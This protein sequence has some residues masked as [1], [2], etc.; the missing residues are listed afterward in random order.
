MKTY[1]DLLKAID[2]GKEMQFVKDCIDSHKSSTLYQEAIVAREY[3]RKRNVTIKVFQK[4]LYDMT[5]QA[6]PDNYSANYKLIN[7][8]FPIFVTQENNYLLG[9]GVT[10]NGKDT[11]D[12]VGGDE[13][14]DVLMDAGEKALWG[15]LSFGFFNVDKVKVFDVTEFAPLW[16]ENDGSLKAGVKFWQID[17]NKPLWAILFKLDGW[18]EYK[19]VAGKKG[20]AVK[21]N[22]PYKL[23]IRTSEFDG[24]EILKGENYPSF[25][26]VPLWANK[27]HQSEFIGLQEKIDC[28]DLIQSGF[29]N[30]IDDASVIYWT[31]QNAGGMDDI[32]LVKF[33]ERMKTVKAA[34]VDE[35]GSS[36]QAHTLEI[37]YA[38]RATL[39][40]DLRDS[41]YRDA[42][43]L[44]T[45]KITAGN[46]TATA[47]KSSY[48][49][50]DLKCDG[51]E[52][53]VSNFIKGI[54]KLANI[55]D[56]P[57]YKRNKIINMQED[58]QMVLSAAQYL[59]DETILKHLPFLSPDEIET[60]LDKRVEEEAA[61]FEE[62]GEGVNGQGE[63]ANR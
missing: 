22:Q 29:A 61:R 43:A 1:Q 14:D 4:L 23:K 31:I 55:D 19:W 62:S 44:D 27:N 6:I 17:N 11:K 5:G 32:D 16:D 47:I 63:E 48:S 25:P 49:N 59:D 46:V 34:V 36:A 21:E 2:E 58:T 13:F 37:P 18:S 33:L 57:S 53:C 3:F 56:S 60:I 8:F 28:Y 38:A 41:L 51:F 52:F 9:N 42:M 50:L 10:F 54:L 30:T 24:M 40:S 45:D 7:A 15:G 12:R 35:N 20:E 26:V 39:L